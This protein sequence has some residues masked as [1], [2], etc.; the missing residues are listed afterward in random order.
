LY[1]FVKK[2]KYYTKSKA[3]LKTNKQKRA[4][5]SFIEITALIFF[6]QTKLLNI[7]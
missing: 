1:F 2:T 6:Q 7:Y 5:I 3:I 4:V